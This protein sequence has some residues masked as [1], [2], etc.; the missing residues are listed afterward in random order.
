MNRK[1]P[2]PRS[3]TQQPSEAPT[4]AAP[5]AAKSVP[6][7]IRLFRRS[8]C[9]WRIVQSLARP[10]GNATGVSA[11]A[12][13]LAGK[14]LN[15]LFE[16]APTIQRVGVLSNPTHPG[17]QSEMGRDAG[18]GKADTRDRSE[19]LSDRHHARR[20][21]GYRAGVRRADRDGLLTFPEGLSLRS[22]A[23]PSS[24]SQ[25]STGIPTAFGWKVYCRGRWPAEL[26]TE[27]LVNFTPGWVS[28]SDSGQKRTSGRSSRQTFP[29]SCRLSDLWR[30]WQ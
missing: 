28:M 19:L 1:V 17:E 4:R 6:V 30:N 12:L 11:M 15:L 23:A 13:E 16:A 18:G 8:G 22:I 27:I 14:R 24:S 26:W 10:G 20:V 3:Q 25:P 2:A 5:L 21:G 29:S 9:R 7:V